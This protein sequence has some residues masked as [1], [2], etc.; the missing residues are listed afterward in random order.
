MEKVK[1]MKKGISYWMF[2]GG[3]DAS[4]GVVDAMQQA[5]EL[6]F[7]SIE[8][9]IASQG[10]LTH[11]TTEGE[12]QEF[13]T[14]AKDIGLE[15]SSLASGESWTCS[16]TA[17]DPAVRS[18]IT[19]FTKQA[20]HVAHWLGVDAYLLVP[21]AVDV[22][23]LPDAEVIPYDVCYDRAVAFVGD[24]LETAEETQVTLCIE[25]VW[26]KF[27][28]SPL[29]MR[30]FIDSFKSDRVGSYFDIGNVLL[31]GY[32]EHWIN[33][34][35]NRIKRVHIK[36]FLLGVTPIE[37]F[38]DLGEGSLDFVKTKAALD[39]I[40]Y[41]GYVTAEVLPFVEGRLEKTAKELDRFVNL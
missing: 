38:V 6:G 36:D 7:D 22:F 17:N 9:C 8:L 16:P 19:S 14:A 4:L 32:P 18:K 5:K 21:G 34:L 40:G 11:Q 39:Q 23:F 28:T 30:A 35:G 24:L 37:G 13:V 26:N 1:T 27:L 2:D 25:N 41:D 15:I 12:C 31:T 10:A 3:L 20:L 29:E 33:I